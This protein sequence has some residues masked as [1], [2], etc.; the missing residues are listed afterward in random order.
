[1]FL[2]TVKEIAEALKVIC[3]VQTWYY[4]YSALYF[5]ILQTSLEKTESEILELSQNAVNLKSNF[6]ELTELK[7]VLEKTETFFIEQEGVNGTDSL[8]R[9]LISEDQSGQTTNIR[10]RL[11]SVQDHS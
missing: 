3:S 1:M 8:T 9:A 2:A 6:L 7:H 5:F 10:G 4:W 11:G